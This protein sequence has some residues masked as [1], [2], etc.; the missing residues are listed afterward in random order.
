[1]TNTMT[2]KGYSTRIGHD[3]EDRIFT[4][5]IADIPDGVGFHA[6][7]VKALREAFH[8]AVGDYHLTCVKTCLPGC[9][10]TRANN[11]L[12]SLSWH[13]ISSEPCPPEAELG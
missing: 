3:D 6:D 2:Y 10:N 5:R 1:M 13:R 4:G 11:P 8:E 9:C 12:I 7:N